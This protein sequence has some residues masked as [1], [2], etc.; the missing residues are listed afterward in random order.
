MY[1]IEGEIQ[2]SDEK[3]RKKLLDDIKETMRY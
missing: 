2:R 1:V 3:M